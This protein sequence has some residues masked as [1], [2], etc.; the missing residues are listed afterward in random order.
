MSDD[1]PPEDISWAWLLVG[2]FML[3]IAVPAYTASRWVRSV[4]RA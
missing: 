3:A 1:N 4:V 2:L